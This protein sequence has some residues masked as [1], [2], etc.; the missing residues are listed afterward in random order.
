MALW[1]VIINLIRL[2]T[3]LIRLVTNLI[4][5][6]TNLIRLLS[7]NIC[8]TNAKLGGT[9]NCLPLNVSLAVSLTRLPY[10]SRSKS[11]NSDRKIAK[12]TIQQLSVLQ[13]SFE[14]CKRY[15]PVL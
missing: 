14:Y 4:R 10:L 13:F 1:T 11:L 3:N 15:R 7:S 2:L 6:L 9:G 5:L 12:H 8:A